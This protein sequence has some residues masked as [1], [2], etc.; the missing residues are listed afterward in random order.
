M[1]PLPIDVEGHNIWGMLA[2]A[3]R[4]YEARD[5]VCAVVFSSAAPFLTIPNI[6]GI[7]RYFISCCNTTHDIT[8]GMNASFVAETA[9]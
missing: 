3:N 2:M 6:R 9:L 8:S 1:E 4:E 5:P 7:C